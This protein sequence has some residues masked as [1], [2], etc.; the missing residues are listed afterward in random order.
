VLALLGFASIAL[1]AVAI[2][3]LY[4]RQHRTDV[5][6]CVIV[7]AEWHEIQRLGAHAGVTVA[8]APPPCTINP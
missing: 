5:Q 1:I 7:A 2:N 6:L 4:D 3:D 8:P